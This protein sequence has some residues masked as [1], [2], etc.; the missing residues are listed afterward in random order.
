MSE[1]TPNENIKK[2]EEV[3]K[4][5]LNHPGVVQARENYLDEVTS[6]LTEVLKLHFDE[7]EHQEKFG[8]ITKEMRSFI[9]KKHM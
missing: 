5:I 7:K 6:H 2:L 8:K 3:K 1:Q 9:E 4:T